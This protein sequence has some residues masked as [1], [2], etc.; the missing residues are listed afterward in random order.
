MGGKQPVHRMPPP[1]YYPAGNPSL[2]TYNQS[3]T[4]MTK[5]LNTKRCL[6]K[7]MIEAVPMFTK[8]IINNLTY[9]Q[10]LPQPPVDRLVELF[11]T[12]EDMATLRRAT[13][14]VG[15][16]KANTQYLV[17]KVPAPSEPRFSVIV[18]YQISQYD[19]FLPDS[20]PSSMDVL[21]KESDEYQQILAFVENAWQ[22]EYRAAH[23]YALTLY[24]SYACKSANELKF[25]WPSFAEPYRSSRDKGVESFVRRFDNAKPSNYAPQTFVGIGAEIEEAQRTAAM[26]LAVGERE[27]VNSTDPRLQFDEYNRQRPRIPVPWAEHYKQWMEDTFSH[28]PLGNHG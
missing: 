17:A 15:S 6:S 24:L 16:R 3:E 18:R 14:L 4:T 11:V 25:L 19:Y 13:E 27:S 22:A 12:P 7:S 28:L 21:D 20:Q 9:I 5:V 23:Y 8:R 2:D 26:T 1:S 10:Q